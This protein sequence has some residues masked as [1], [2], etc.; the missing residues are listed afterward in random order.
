MSISV[1]PDG[2]ADECIDVDV[3]KSTLLQFPFLLRTKCNI[4]VSVT[5]FS[6]N[7]PQII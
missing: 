2:F 4:T 1:M 5:Y 6:S 7:V 3:T